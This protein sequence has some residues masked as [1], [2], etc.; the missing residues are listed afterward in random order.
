MHS[1]AFAYSLKLED[2]EVF[3]RFPAIPEII[4]S[5]SDDRFKEMSS[6]EIQAFADDAVLTWLQLC[7]S[8]RDD[9]PEPEDLTL[10]QLHGIVRLTPIVAM[11]L[12]LYRVFRANCRSMAEFS[13]KIGKRDTNAR[14]LLDLTHSS[15]TKEVNNALAVFGKRLVHGWGI[16]NLND[17]SQYKGAVLK[18]A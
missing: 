4:S 7:I 5:V 17:P 2:G 12:E 13:R 3:F 6:G 11:K 9:L 8:A 15:Q 16:E 1:Y 14:R 10:V 18:A